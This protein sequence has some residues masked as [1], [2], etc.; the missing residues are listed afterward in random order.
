[1]KRLSLKHWP[2]LAKLC[3]IIV[4]SILPL[5]IV[6]FFETLPKI[7][8]KVYLDKKDDLRHLVESASGIMNAYNYKVTSGFMSL[9][10]AQNAAAEEID[11]LRYEGKEYFFMYD[12]NGICKALGSDPSKIGTD[13]SNLVD[14]NGVKYVQDMINICKDKGQGFIEYSY[15]KLGSSIP[16]PKLAYV[17]LFE[18][19]G[20]FIG[21]GVYTD[22]VAAEV[23]AFSRQIKL[24]ILLAIV[25]ALGL[26][27]IISRT[28]GKPIKKLEEA[29]LAVAAGNVDIQTDVKSEDEIGT[30]ASSFNTMVKNIKQSMHEAKQNAETASRSAEEAEKARQ[31]TDAQGKHLAD[32]VDEMLKTVGQFADGDLRVKLNIE[33]DDEIGKLFK[34]FNDATENIRNMMKGISAMSDELAAASAQISASSEELASGTGDQSR[35]TSEVA[36]AVEEMSTTII[37]TTKNTTN[38][39]DHAKKAGEIA[40]GGSALVK[41]T[42]NGIE[43]ISDVVGSAAATI[44]R[45]GSSSD[46]IGDII[47]VIE[48]IADQTNLLALNAAIEAARAGEEGRGFAVVADEVRKLAERTTK[49]TKEIAGVIK[50]IQSETKEAVTSINNGTEVVS[51]G[52]ELAKRAGH[53][54]E[55][56]IAATIIVMDEASQVATASE[57]QSSTAEEISK[58][59]VGINNITR[60]SAEGIQEIAKAAEDLNRLTERLNM[61]IGEFRLS[62]DRE[63][64]SRKQLR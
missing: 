55:E 42:Y 25:L 5:M 37:S 56:I 12:M 48:D 63:Y 52:K 49:A 24:F 40:K 7:E 50:Q 29:A 51:S 28:I 60:Q 17:Q 4:V 30:L 2:L 34:G 27:Y 1:M 59:V 16:F 9:E 18:P 39:S 64:R 62:D 44:S 15:P 43:K 6:Y 61:M 45:L 57:E 3:A 21:T 38:V 14:A 35:Q 8:D 22:D 46:K 33:K 58:N 54:L 26:G 11:A 36:S 20:W 32:K 23:A 53:A 41:D 31:I 19:W 13:R 10:N 47:T